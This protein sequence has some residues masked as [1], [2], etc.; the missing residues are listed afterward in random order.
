M[1][2]LTNAQITALTNRITDELETIYAA[3]RVELEASKE[4]KEFE[5]DTPLGKDIQSYLKHYYE[6]EAEIEEL[7]KRQEERDEQL[8]PLIKNHP[9]H[10]RYN[11]TTSNCKAI[12]E[13]E[14]DLKFKSTKF[15]RDKVYNKVFSDIILSSGTDFDPNEL[16][17]SL[18]NTYR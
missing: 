2:K 8:K 6:W 17:T 10:H 1:R 3:K 15:D 18:I 5:W 16:V 14:R 12:V 13:Y 11:S 7:K 4:F 9:T